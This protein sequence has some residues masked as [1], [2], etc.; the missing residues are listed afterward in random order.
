MADNTVLNT[1][2]G[3]DTI[4]D[5]ART[6]NSPA[7][8]QVVALDIG[9]A[10]DSN[11]ESIIS[12]TNPMP[13]T[14]LGDGVA[15]DSIN[16]GTGSNNGLMVAKGATDFFTS[17]GNTSVGQLA[18]GA[19]FTGTIESVVNAQDISIDAASDQAGTLVVN[20][21]ITSSAGT[22]CQTASFPLVAIGAAF[23]LARS[24]PLNGNFFNLKF[25]NNGGSTTTTLNINTAYG[26]IGVSTQLLNTATALNEVNGAAISLGQAAMAASLPVTLA[27][28]QSTLPVSIATAPVLVAGSALIGG[29]NLID[30][31]GTTKASVKAA[32]TAAAAT[33]TSIVVQPL[34]GSHVMNTAA[35]GTQLVGI[36]GNAAATLDAVI[37]AATAPANALATLAVY[38]TTIPALT[39][40]QSV[41]IQ[42]DTAGAVYVDTAGRRNTYSASTGA[43]TPV[44]AVTDPIW[45]IIGSASKTVRITHIN[46]SI[47]CATGTTTPA[48]VT[49]KKLSALTGGTAVAATAVPHDS[50]NAAATAVVDSYSTV[51]TSVTALGALRTAFL[52]WVTGGA[53]VAQ[54][55]S[56]VDW[57]FGDDGG[58]QLVLRGTSQ[59]L[60]LNL[61]AI[62]T[63]PTME[64]TVE[65]IEDN[66]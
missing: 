1:G 28:N 48:T 21:Y 12:A 19:S 52:Q 39:N 44:A 16:L 60:A 17:V 36:V 63:T 59:W 37:T 4:R 9:G 32:S 34:V 23:G 13:V 57:F 35:A 25:T 30:T 61:S 42:C 38:E 55:T 5:I 15:I 6:A 10:S 26:T 20:Q 22:I 24:F 2:S 8:T 14:V 49:L 3:G 46:V 66:S 54:P 50:A 18:A 29:V 40:G 45:S 7:K 31:G 43:I 62:G 64:I 47:F 33:D 27:S 58:Q 41:A 65:W 53:T 56:T 11:A 51:P